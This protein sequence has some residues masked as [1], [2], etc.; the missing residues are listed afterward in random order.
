MSL[1]YYYGQFGELFH[2]LLKPLAYLDFESGV[3]RQSATK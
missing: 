2:S 1:V 3:C